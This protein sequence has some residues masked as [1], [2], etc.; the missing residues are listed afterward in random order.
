MGVDH[1]YV[2]GP[3]TGIRDHNIPAFD[4]AK[5]WIERYTEYKADTPA[6]VA[7][8][9]AAVHGKHWQDGG[10]APPK[11]VI[12]ALQREDFRRV[13]D[14]R[15]VGV[16][17]IVGWTE[18][19]KLKRW[20][21]STGTLKELLLAQTIGLRFYAFEEN[22]TG[23]GEQE[24]CRLEEIDLPKVQVSVPKT[25]EPVTGSVLLEAQGLVHGPRQKDYGHP[26]DNY[27]TVAALWNGMLVDRYGNNRAVSPALAAL[28]MLQVKVAREL[29]APKRDNMVD[30]AGYS[31]V[32]NM[33]NEVQNQE[34]NF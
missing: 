1:L 5:R 28:M 17:L 4:R 24:F 31:E 15:T 7:R 16:A 21:D 3:M 25:V 14:T 13:L 2:A 19:G 10:E 29:H 18:D 30:A 34:E 11:H 23:C 6:D 33:I 27:H 12:E 8:A 22:V 32:V 20:E 26:V 9:Y